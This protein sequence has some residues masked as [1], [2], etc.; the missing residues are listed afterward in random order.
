MTVLHF[1]V[2]ARP[3]TRLTKVGA[4]QAIPRWRE[5]GELDI[6]VNAYYSSESF[7]A[8][9]GV[10]ADEKLTGG[11]NRSDVVRHLHPKL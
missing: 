1:A 8:G 5:D 2:L 3:Q 4:E 7:E 9:L 11:S 6:E 10:R